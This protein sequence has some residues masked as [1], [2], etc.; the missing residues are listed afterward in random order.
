MQFRIR[1]HELVIG[2]WD[3]FFRDDTAGKLALEVGS[4]NSKILL[5]ELLFSHGF[6]V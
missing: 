5:D 4:N 6:P 3:R 1:H 2:I